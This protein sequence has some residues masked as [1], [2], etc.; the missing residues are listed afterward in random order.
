MPFLACF[1]RNDLIVGI[2]YSLSFDSITAVCPLGIFSSSVGI[3]DIFLM[4]FPAGISLGLISFIFF[5]S[6]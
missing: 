6:F 4:L 3:I 2:L 5:T 1:V